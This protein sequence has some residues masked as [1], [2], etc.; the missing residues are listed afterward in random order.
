VGDPFEELNACEANKLHGD[1]RHQSDDRPFA[2]A[3]HDDRGSEPGEHHCNERPRSE[4]QELA[5]VGVMVDLGVIT[6]T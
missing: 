4:G 1:E 5:M 3:A 2:P 6:V